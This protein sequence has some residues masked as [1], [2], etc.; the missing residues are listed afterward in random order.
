MYKWNYKRIKTNGEWVLEHRHIME[1]HIGRKLLQEEHVHHIDGNQK[2]NNIANLA[3]LS[4]G[5]HTILHHKGCEHLVVSCT[6]CKKLFEVT[7]RYERFKRKHNKYGLFCSRKCVG[8]FTN[9][10]NLNCSPL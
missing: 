9:K 8:I 10:H 7:A 6:N 5:E 4:N 1:Q 2:N 3:I